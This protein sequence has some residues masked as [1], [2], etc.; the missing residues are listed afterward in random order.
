MTRC[1][2]CHQVLRWRIYPLWHPTHWG[3]MTA[4]HTVPYHTVCWFSRRMSVWREE[5]QHEGA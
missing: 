1:Q 2:G 3:A 4:G 5:A